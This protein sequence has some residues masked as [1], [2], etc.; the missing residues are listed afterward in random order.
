M[1]LTGAIDFTKNIELLLFNNRNKTQQISTC[2]NDSVNRTINRVR[3]AEND[4]VRKAA[5]Q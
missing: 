5:H 1:K 4:G 2:D 3:K